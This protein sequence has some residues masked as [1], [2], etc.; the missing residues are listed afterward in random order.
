MGTPPPRFS[1]PVER[2]RYADL[3]EAAAYAKVHPRTIRR[4][5]SAGLLPAFRAGPRLLR[6]DLNQVDAMLRP[7]PTAGAPDDAA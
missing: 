3:A 6:I 5:V 7:I 1:T 4:W 2:A